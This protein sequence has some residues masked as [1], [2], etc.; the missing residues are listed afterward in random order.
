MNQ[1][2]IVPA[3]SPRPIAATPTPAKKV[4]RWVIVAQCI[5]CKKPIYV[6]KVGPVECECGKEMYV[7]ET[8]GEWPEW[9]FG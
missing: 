8:E 1:I 5:G 6:E 2:A 9:V 7:S 4:K 3:G